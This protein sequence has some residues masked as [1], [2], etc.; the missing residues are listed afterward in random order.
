MVV[1]RVLLGIPRPVEAFPCGSISTMSVGAPTAARAVPRLI[2][3]VVLPTPPFWLATT[4]MR[5]GLMAVSMAQLPDIENDARGVRTAG[6]LLNRHAP[7]LIGV[8]QFSPYRLALEEQALGILSLK[9]GCIGKQLIE[10]CTGACGHDV[11]RLRLRVFDPAVPDLGGDPRPMDDFLKKT[12]L[13]GDG[14]IEDRADFTFRKDS[15]NDA[16]KAGATTE[17]DEIFH[18]RSEKRKKLGRI[19]NMPLPDVGEGFRGDEI[20]PRVPIPE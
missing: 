7:R 19:P 5:G 16:W 9:R 3:V 12:A 20:H 18:V 4:R 11:E 10:R 13:L 6:M 1:C 8:G 2:A 17:I 15:Q 14:L